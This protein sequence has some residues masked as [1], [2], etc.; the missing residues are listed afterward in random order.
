MTAS[1]RIGSVLRS[2][3]V[4]ALC[5]LS[6]ELQKLCADANAGHQYIVTTKTTNIAATAQKYDLTVIR[7]IDSAGYVH[8]VKS[9]DSDS[10][11]LFV[12]QAATDPAISSV[13]VDH[14]TDVPESDNTSKASPVH[15]IDPLT[16]GSAALMDY[17]GDQVRSGYVQQP[18]ATL[19][20]LAAAH[21]QYTLGGGIV[22]VIDTGIDPS[23]PALQR[24]IVPGYDFVN[25]LPGVP[26]ETAD[27][28]QSTVGLLD[29]LSTQ[30]PVQVN[31]STVGLLDQ[32][33]VGL[34]DGNQL[35]GAFG[36]GTMTAGLIHL[37]APNARIMPI[38][39]FLSDGTGTISNIVSAIYFAA[40]HGAKVIN[41]SFSST[42]ASQSLADA[43]KYAAGKG[44]TCVASSGNQGGQVTVYP[45]ADSGV[46][47]VA[48]TNSKDNRSYFSNRG[49][50]STKM[51]APGEA[52]ITSYPGG[53]YAGVW[54]TSF[55]TAL[56]SGAVALVTQ[57]QPKASPGTVRDDIGHGHPISDDM[58]I[59]DSRLD[60]LASLVY[61]LTHHDD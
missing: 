27:V 20:N 50:P 6:P 23:H 25:N 44:A 60:V 4:A 51:A 47:G 7:T 40:D 12:K 56:V 41:M 31:Q 46:I 35:P 9:E 28:S 18:V 59:G 14:S 37:V 21:S 15:S 32:S 2:A 34:L 24:W 3:L 48:S 10:D 43:V 8:L 53:H 30:V 16:P 19:I 17:Y 57:L 45:A 1:N 61:S 58:A 22:A 36:H 29:R 49:V 5:V 26:N 52:L 11:T 55:S 38:K 13:E 54:G 42:T 39:A 33:T